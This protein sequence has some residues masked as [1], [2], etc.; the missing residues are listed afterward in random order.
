MSRIPYKNESPHL[1]EEEGEPLLSEFS[2][3]RIALNKKIIWEIPYFMLPINFKRKYLVLH[4]KSGIK[5]F[6]QQIEFF[7][8]E[9]SKKE[10]ELF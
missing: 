2:T 9:R 8:V 6:Y 1:Y 4:K 10:N 5:F 7:S 3:I